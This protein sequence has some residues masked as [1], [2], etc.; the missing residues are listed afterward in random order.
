MENCGSRWVASASSIRVTFPSTNFRR[1]YTS[2]KSSPTARPTGRT[3][4]A[5]LFAPAPAPAGSRSRDRLHR[6][7]FV[8]PEKVRFRVKLEGHDPDWKDV[9][10]ERKAFYTDLPPRHYRFRV[11]ACNNSG[12]WNE[13]GDSLDFSIDPAYYQTTWFKAVCG[14]AFLM[15]LW[16]LYRYRLHRIAR[17]FN[18]RLEERVGERTRIAR[19]LHDT[20]L[21]SF[22]GLMLRFQVGVDR[23]P[24]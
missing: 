10:T 20:L 9:G 18:A 7:S 11:M 16:A 12:L 23:V 5:W 14:A 22:Q 13:A 6:V 24:R 19:E 8:T 2:S 21:Q 3:L 15:L 1:R 4:L 17:E